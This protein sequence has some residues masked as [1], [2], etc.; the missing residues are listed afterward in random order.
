MFYLTFIGRYGMIKNMM[1]GDTLPERLELE[2]FEVREEMT[3]R[4]LNVVVYPGAEL[5]GELQVN[6][7]MLG[8]EGETTLRAFY[9][10][11][12]GGGRAM[13]KEAPT[14]EKERVLNED[15]CL[16]FVCDVYEG[17]FYCCEEDLLDFMERVLKKVLKRED[18]QELVEA[19]RS[20]TDITRNRLGCKYQFLYMPEKNKGYT[21]D[22]VE[23][24]YGFLTAMLV[25]ILTKDGGE[26]IVDG[27]HSGKGEFSKEFMELFSLLKK[28]AKKQ[29]SLKTLGKAVRKKAGGKKWILKI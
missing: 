17:R 19:L 6:G 13:F 5:S 2:V 9:R 18:P 25:G 1:V 11:V 28:A 16:L 26:K 7:L 20:M 27:Y 22:A 10:I 12:Y 21:L 14:V 15:D 23:N 24:D 3:R 8:E 29:E 4:V